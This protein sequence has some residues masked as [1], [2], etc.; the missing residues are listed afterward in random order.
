MMSAA[1]QDSAWIEEESYLA[2]HWDEMTISNPA[3]PVAG[4]WKDGFYICIY[5]DGNFLGSN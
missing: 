3:V 4:I 5:C 1:L 2:E